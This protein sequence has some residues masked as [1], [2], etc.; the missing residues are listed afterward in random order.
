M[1]LVQINVAAFAA[2]YDV[3]IG[4]QGLPAGTPWV[5][6]VA[7]EELQ[8]EYDGW[9]PDVSALLRCMPEKV[10]RWAVHVDHPPLESYAKGRAALLGDAVRT[11][12]IFRGSDMMLHGIAL[13]W[14]G[15]LR[16]MG[17]CLTWELGQ[18]RVSK[19]RLF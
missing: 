1:L 10:S 19:T 3:P 7:R 4:S 14:Y 12:L 18:D 2:R 5:E 11:L 8:K 9:G 13:T 17:C 16:P 6:D 15:S